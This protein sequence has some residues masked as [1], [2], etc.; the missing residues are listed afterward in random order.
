MSFTP[1][2]IAAGQAIYTRRMLF[3][4]DLRVLWLSNPLVWKCPTSR[5]LAQYDRL[6]SSNHLDVG[7]G[8]GYYLDKCFFPTPN[9]RVV[10]M[11]LNPNSLAFAAQRIARYKPQTFVRNVLEPI[12]FDDA[13]FDTVAVNYLL[14][15]LPGDMAAKACV[16][17]HLQPL[18]N[19][20]AVIFGST[21]LQGGVTRSAAARALMAHYNRLGVFSNTRDDLDTLRRELERRFDAVSIEVVGCAAVLSARRR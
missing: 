12:P 1:E 19:P 5:L 18:M 7:V 17:D 2:E 16:F 20:G 10:L 8:S 9:P 21:L 14:H 11:D 6:V 4:Y 13:G 3:Y 15:C